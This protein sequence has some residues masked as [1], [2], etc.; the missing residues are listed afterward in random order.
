MSKD[1]GL[2]HDKY[3]T[4]RAETLVSLGWKEV[5]PV[6]PDILEWLRDINWP[7]AG[8]FRPFLVDVGAPLAPF[9][10]TVLATDDDVWKYGILASVVSQSPELAAALRSDLELLCSTPSVGE[11]LEGVSELARE[12]LAS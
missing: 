7:V 11:Q 4:E 5:L 6:M 2:P 1:F 3:D 10:K 9:I 12:I 8:V